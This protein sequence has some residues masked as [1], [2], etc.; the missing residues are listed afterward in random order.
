MNIRFSHLVLALVLTGVV[1]IAGCATTPT[2]APT[3]A[4]TAIPTAIPKPTDVPP[5]NTA[6]PPTPTTAPTITPLPPTN[7]P[8]PTTPAPTATN[9]R[10]PVTRQPT[11]TAVPTETNV[12]LKFP[13]PQLIEP[14]AGDTRVSGSDDLIF[15]WHPVAALG[16]DE[17]YLVT[18]RITNTVDNEY[19]EQSFLA[20]NTCNDGGSAPVSFTL[21]KRS[22][23]P[24]YAGLVAIASAK[25]P[26]TSFV[27]RW[28]VTVV[29]NRGADPNKPDP[30]QFSPIS[31]ASEPLEFS[32]L[33]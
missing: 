22:P 3:V 24:D 30:A 20:Q 15:R 27:V 19:G 21:R 8:I 14:G 13:A 31:P 16:T 32:L 9:T 29:Q 7:T 11:A 25:S 6:L 4:P 2:P 1:G 5:T 17:C 28:F 23:A 10:V 33:G 18:V 12:A 26:S